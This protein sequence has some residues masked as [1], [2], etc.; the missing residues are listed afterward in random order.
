VQRGAVLGVLVRIDA[1][2][3]VAGAGVEVAVRAELDHAA[4]VVGE[5]VGDREHDPGAVG[6]GGVRVVGPGGQAL[7]H[8]RLG[9][10]VVD[11]EGAV[12][13]VIGVEGQAEQAL[14]VGRSDPVADVEERRLEQDLVLDDPDLAVAGHHE[15]AGVVRRRGDQ[16][17]ASR[18]LD[19]GDPAQHQVGA[20]PHLAVGGRAR[21]RVGRWPVRRRGV[22]Q[23][24]RGV[25]RGGVARPRVGGAAAAPAAGVAVVAAGEQGERGHRG[26]RAGAH[27]PM[28]LVV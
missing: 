21:P 20:G 14:L 4:V 27:G 25:E 13:L 18:A 17:G 6:V 28:V 19:G 8:V 12:L 7:D 5:A 9:R 15:Q 16:D 23:A 26:G 10:R 1:A 11:E 24:G 2:A 3:A 22:E